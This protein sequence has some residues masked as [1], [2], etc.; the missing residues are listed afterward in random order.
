MWFQSPCISYHWSYISGWGRLSWSVV[1]N[2]Y[3]NVYDCIQRY[4][5]LLRVILFVLYPLLIGHWD[6]F[7]YI[8]NSRVCRTVEQTHLNQ[9]T[10]TSDMHVHNKRTAMLYIVI[11]VHVYTKLPVCNVCTLFHRRKQPTHNTCTNYRTRV[12]N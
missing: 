10:W 2:R 7:T 11:H 8:N 3:I 12:V 9:Q 4:K 1:M 6:T 5:S